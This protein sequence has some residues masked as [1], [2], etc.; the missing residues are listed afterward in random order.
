MRPCTMD[1]ADIIVP[2]EMASLVDEAWYQL[3]TVLNFGVFHRPKKCS[4]STQASDGQSKLYTQDTH[5]ASVLALA[6]FSFLADNY[7]Q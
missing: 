1:A 2:Q 7:G 6:T 3:T 5:L 4:Y